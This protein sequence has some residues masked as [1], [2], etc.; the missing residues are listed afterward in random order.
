MPDLLHLTGTDKPILTFQH[1]L[2]CWNASF[3]K[4]IVEKFPLSSMTAN[5]FSL[6]ISMS[7][8]F[9]KKKDKSRTNWKNDLLYLC[10]R[11]RF[12]FESIDKQVIIRFVLNNDFLIVLTKKI[13]W[14]TV[15]DQHTLYCTE[16]RVLKT[17]PLMNYLIQSLVLLRGHLYTDP[18]AIWFSFGNRSL[19]FYRCPHLDL[20]ILSLK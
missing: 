15:I 16:I 3:Y 18:K 14:C 17:D 20:Y 4:I 8:L 9:A 11:K 13:L 19:L 12:V 2:V 10:L 5:K 1:F 6:H 7:I